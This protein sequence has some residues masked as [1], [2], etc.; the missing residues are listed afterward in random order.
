[1][2]GVHGNADFCGKNPVKN[3][4]RGTVGASVG[5][6]HQQRKQLTGQDA[7]GTWEAS[8]GRSTRQTRNRMRTQAQ[9]G[10]CKLAKRYGTRSQRSSLSAR[11]RSGVPLRSYGHR[12][13][14]LANLYSKLAMATRVA[15]ANP[16]RSRR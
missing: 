4:V 3:P 8:T 9:E 6:C 7:H 2:V 16:V 1:M 11:F 5:A 10:L 14:E 13:L 15:I 12:V